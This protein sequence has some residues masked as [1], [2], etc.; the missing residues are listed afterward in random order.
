MHLI[1][2]ISPRSTVH[3]DTPWGWIR[4]EAEKFIY[5]HVHPFF[6]DD[7]FWCVPSH[8]DGWMDVWSPNHT[9]VLVWLVVL[10]KLSGIMLRKRSLAHHFSHCY[11]R[12]CRRRRMPKMAS[13]WDQPLSWKHFSFFHSFQWLVKIGFASWYVV[14]LWRFPM[15]TWNVRVGLV[16]E[17]SRSVSNCEWCRLSIQFLQI[18]SWE[19]KNITRVQRQWGF[20]VRFEWL[21]RLS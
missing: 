9:N 1:P 16:P 11:S 20:F 5:H 19:T 15:R 2:S 17:L 18:T 8:L 13:G 7:F 6:S 4:Y 21:Y 14:L 12:S 3:V 10:V